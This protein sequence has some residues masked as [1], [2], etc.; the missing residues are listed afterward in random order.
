MRPVSGGATSILR[1]LCE[2]L[3][4]DERYQ[5]AMLI[6][7]SVKTSNAFQPLSLEMFDVPTGHSDDQSLKNLEGFLLE[8]L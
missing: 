6:S 1:P 3:S 7:P 2:K 5:L 4:A 8:Q